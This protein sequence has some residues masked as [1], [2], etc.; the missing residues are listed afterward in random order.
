MAVIHLLGSQGCL[1]V[2]YASDLR[3]GAARV[4]YEESTHLAFLP[5][6]SVKASQMLRHCSC[7]HTDQQRTAVSY[8]PKFHTTTYEVGFRPPFWSCLGASRQGRVQVLTWWQ[9][10]QRIMFHVAQTGCNMLL[11]E[12]MHQRCSSEA[13]RPPGGIC[14][15][16]CPTGPPHVALLPHT[17]RGTLP[18]C[19][20][21][22]EN[23][24]HA[25]LC[26]T[27]ARRQQSLSLLL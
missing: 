20:T 8:F 24:S 1:P 11:S 9:L 6:S 19:S 27:D 2:Q 15:L 7:L 16:Q 18:R 4:S 21:S 5:S 17:L 26:P 22:N 3:A 14:P 25:S 23:I 12:I 13:S 10:G